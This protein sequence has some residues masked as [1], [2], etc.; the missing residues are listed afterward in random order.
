[1]PET[2]TR[3][4]ALPMGYRATFSFTPATQALQIEW[5]PA[6]PSIQSPRHRRKFFEAYQDARREFFVDVATSIGGAVAV[7]DLTGELEVIRPSTK[8]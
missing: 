1:M 6:V 4:L 3:T 8:H 2:I 7:A 5:E